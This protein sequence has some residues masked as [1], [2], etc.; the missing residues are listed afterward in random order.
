MAVDP[1]VV[2]LRERRERLGWTQAG[3]AHRAGMSVYTLRQVE[4]GRT[5]A[6][7]VD[8]LRAIAGAMGLRVTLGPHLAEV[9]A[10][11]EGGA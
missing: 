5:L 6:P 4:S 11:R 10:A 1:I 3:L 7:R 9:G 2:S 8:T